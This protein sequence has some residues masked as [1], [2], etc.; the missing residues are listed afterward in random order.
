MRIL[1]LYSLYFAHAL[2]LWGIVVSLIAVFKRDLRG[3][4]SS[5]RT[6]ISIFVLTT[7]SVLSLLTAFLRN[8]FTIRYV[9]D[10]SRTTQ[11]LIYKISALW[12]GMDGSLLFWEWLLSFY[13]L[14]AIYLAR[15][16]IFNLIPFSSFI[17]FFVQGFF[18][19][20]LTFKTNPFAPLLDS[21]GVAVSSQVASTIDGNGL[22]PLLQ[23]LYMAIHP[24]L[25]YLGF[26]GLTIPF[27]YLLSALWERE[28]KPLYLVPL[29]YWSLYS[30]LTLGMGI[31]FGSYWAYLELGWGGYWAWDPVENASLMPFLTATAFLH[32]LFMEKKRGLFKTLN[33]FLVVVTF[34]LSIYGTYLTRSGVLQSVHSFGQESS[35]VPWFFQ[36]GNIF[37]GFMSLTIILSL[38]V[39][40][41]RRDILKS[42]GEIESS[43]SKESMVLYGNILFIIFTAFVFFGVTSP[44]FYRIFYG[45]ELHNGVEFYS[46]KAIPV[47]LLI[48][49]VMAIA[50]V[51]PWGKGNKGNLKKS[52]VFPAI[53]GLITAFSG[54]L[55]LYNNPFFFNSLSFKGRA[56]Y[57][58]LSLFAIS[59]F[60]VTLILQE[61]YRGMRRSFKK[62]GNFFSS[63]LFFA[64]NPRRY[65]GYT[66]HLG[67]V[68]F[69]IGVAFSS[70]F[71][72][73]FEES[74]KVKESF[75]A[76]NVVFQ[77]DSLDNDDFRTDIS[78]V[79]ELKIWASVNLFKG[80]KYIGTLIPKRVHYKTTIETNEPP[81]YEVA[82]KSSLFKD[83]YLILSGFDI[84]EGSAILTLFVN[85]LV[86]WLWIGS[87]FI[88]IGGIIAMLGNF[89][90]KLNCKL[91]IGNWKF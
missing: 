49:L 55:V 59:G 20:L 87:F 21:S 57:Y 79:N 75:L 64:D 35:S 2:A 8:D 3:L 27:A 82:I 46:P 74:L 85:P 60:S 22:N 71:Q 32:S 45:K 52:L 70:T 37:L 56:I 28:K 68:L 36:L 13:S 44:I 65:G 38:I 4:K 83:Y 89:L 66:V 43:L 12:G 88:L 86:S 51:A 72:Q 81:S 9:Y 24:P 7:I 34:V 78:K 91:K 90:Q 53:I 17:F 77:L 62:D 16:K 25:L 84:N 73:K 1:G 50:T 19:F 14:L 76:D 31:V 15:K 48:L 47:T 23:N 69:C 18:L 29:R 67:V 10:Y 5:E 63:L 6:L 26:V 33:Y 54:F 40:F 58:F 42:R 11:P 39:A 41:L 61:F 80:D 30:W